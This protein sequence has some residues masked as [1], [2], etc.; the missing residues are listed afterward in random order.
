MEQRKITRRIIVIDIETS[1]LDYNASILEVAAVDLETGDELVFA[2]HISNFA[3]IDPQAFQIN[4]YFERGVWENML[5]EES[6]IQHYQDLEAMLE[7]NVL[8]AANPAFDSRQLTTGNPPAIRATW[9]HRLG[10]VSTYAAGKLDI[11][12]SDIPG[13]FAVCEKLDVPAPDHSALGDARAAAECIRRLHARRPSRE[14][15]EQRD[16]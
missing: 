10:D 4:R 1:A 6:T 7:G 15:V 9:H 13:L 14:I 8:A 11:P 12:L 3:V 5:D 16:Y 2:P